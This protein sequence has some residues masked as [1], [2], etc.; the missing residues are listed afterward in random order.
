ML[1]CTA[2]AR[3]TSSNASSR[4]SGA[5]TLRAMSRLP[6]WQPKNGLPAMRI[7]SPVAGST[8]MTSMPRSARLIGPNGPARYWP[9]SMSRSR[10]SGP[11]PFDPSVTSRASALDAD[12]A[13]YLLVVLADAWLRAADLARGPE[14]IDRD[15]DLDQRAEVGIVDRHHHAVRV[16]LRMR[17]GERLLH[18]DDRLDRDVVRQELVDELLALPALERVAAPGVHQHLLLQRQQPLELLGGRRLDAEDLVHAL[19]R[20]QAAHHA[21][22]HELAISA[23]ED[24]PLVHAGRVALAH[25]LV[26]GGVRLLDVLPDLGRVQERALQQARRHLLTP[27]RPLPG[28]ERG[29]DPRRHEEDRPHA[30]HRHVQED[31]PRPPPRLL[32]LLARRRLH[33]RVVAGAVREA[34]PGR[35]RRH[36]AVHE[37]GELGVQR[38]VADAETVHHAGPEA[39]DD[40]VGGGG[41]LA[42]RVDA[43]GG[44]QVARERPARARPHL[45]AVVD[46]ERISA[47]RLDFDD[48]GALLR[49]QQHPERA[50]D[51]PRQVEDADAVERASHRAL[52]LAHT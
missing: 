18:R 25:Q 51:A 20:R 19:L 40:H 7:P 34:V 31:R 33:E 26:E 15:A 39:L 37:A 16:E 2:S 9:T 28:D 32:P 22:V 48:V 17:P 3:R 24:H 46:A 11:A 45:V 13:P 6:R 49:E 52:S 43:G 30:R 10:S 47:R 44:L 5:L 21:H 29:E 35:V 50:R 23:L 14:E 4:P 12:F 41:E 27:A 38:V 1:W 42:E 8:L 36:R